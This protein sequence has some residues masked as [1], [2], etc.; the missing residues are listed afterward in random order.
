MRTFDAMC[1]LSF[2]QCDAVRCS[3]GLPTMI[4][5]T[6]TKT[7][8]ATV[9]TTVGVGYFG[10][11]SVW[12]TNKFFL[13]SRF[14]SSTQWPSTQLLRYVHSFCLNTTE[15]YLIITSIKVSKNLLSNFWASTFN[16]STLY[17]C[18]LVSLNKSCQQF[19]LEA[20]QWVL[21][22]ILFSVFYLLS[23]QCLSSQYLSIQCHGIQCLN[24]QCLSSMYVV[25]DLFQSDIKMSGCRCVRKILPI[26]HAS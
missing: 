24:S 15:L 18:D 1:A 14:R 8:T 7:R 2:K 23:N 17:N 19:D 21:C 12:E 5:S 13:T 3:N 6:T 25:S 22:V 16:F 4:S 9:T 10:V 11:P 20:E 26:W